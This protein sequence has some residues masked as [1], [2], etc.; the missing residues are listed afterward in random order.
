MDPKSGVPKMPKSGV[1]KKPAYKGL[2]G[3]APLTS[4]A[5]WRK[6]KIENCLEEDIE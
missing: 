1:P 5:E 4:E 6:L 3:L 2:L